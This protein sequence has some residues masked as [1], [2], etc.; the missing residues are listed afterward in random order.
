MRVDAV[1][2][3]RQLCVWRDVVQAADDVTRLHYVSRKKPK[4]RYFLLLEMLGLQ[5]CV[6]NL[7]IFIK[8]YHEHFRFALTCHLNVQERVRLARSKFIHL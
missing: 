3:V 8:A 2:R 4:K 7:E 6:F 1:A 5:N